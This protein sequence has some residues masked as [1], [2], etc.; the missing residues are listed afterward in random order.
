[1]SPVELTTSQR[2]PTMSCSRSPPTIGVPPKMWGVLRYCAMMPLSSS[3]EAVNSGVTSD[4]S[5]SPPA[6]ELHGFT[7]QVSQRC[8]V[9]ECACMQR[10]GSRSRSLD[11]IQ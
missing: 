2:P 6:V 8:H 7:E 9:H 10:P 5:M 1:M 4:R 3:S 11:V